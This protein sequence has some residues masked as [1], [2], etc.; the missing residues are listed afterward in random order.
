MQ[1]CNDELTRA[2]RYRSE[3]SIIIVDIDNFKQVNDQFGHAK[4]DEIL[5]LVGVLL[6]QAL[7]ENDAVGR[8]GGD[9]F[10]LLLI[11]S[12]RD[13][14]CAIAERVRLSILDIPEVKNGKLPISASVGLAQWSPEDNSISS[15]IQRADRFMYQAKEQ[16][17]NSVVS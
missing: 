12:T 6:K 15:I 1:E 7:R 4:G 8:L 14:A 17:K 9:E 16:G 5:I 2:K 3:F 10:C 11:N 13:E